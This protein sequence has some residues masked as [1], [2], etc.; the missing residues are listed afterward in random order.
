MSSETQ[1][2]LKCDLAHNP[3]QKISR[4]DFLGL[5][6][7]WTC[8]TASTLSLIGL[9]K[10]PKP[11]LLPDVSNIFKIGRPEDIPLGS[12]TIIEDKKVLVRRDSEGI[13]AISLICTHLGCIV[14]KTN[15]G[16]FSCPCHGSKFSKKGNVLGGPAPRELSWLEISQLPNGKLVVNASKRIPSGTKFVV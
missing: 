14:S 3:E 7:L 4:R 5:A 9:F 1:N 13:A 2:G 6:A 12:E 16:G 8:I 11:A 10:F 15:T